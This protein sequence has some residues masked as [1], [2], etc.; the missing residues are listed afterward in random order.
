M[1]TKTVLLVAL[2]SLLALPASASDWRLYERAMPGASWEKVRIVHIVTNRLQ[3]RRAAV[4][5]CG[6]VYRMDGSPPKDAMRIVGP[7]GTEETI[8]CAD[9]RPKQEPAPKDG[10]ATINPW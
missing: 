9:V 5:R 10:K 8:V 3:V 6:P 1:N 4:D 7:D 2:M